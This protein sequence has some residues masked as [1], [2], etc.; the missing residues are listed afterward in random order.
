MH[1]RHVC[2]LS[3]A[4][5]RGDAT[6]RRASHVSERADRLRWCVCELY[7]RRAPLRRLRSRLCHGTAVCRWYLHGYT[8]TIR[9][10]HD[11]CASELFGGPSIL[12][13]VLCR[14]EHERDPLRRL[15][16][17]LHC[18]ATL[19]RRCMHRRDGCRSTLHGHH[20]GLLF[21]G[22]RELARQPDALWHV[23]Q[24]LPRGSDLRRWTLRVSPSHGRGPDVSCGACVLPRH[25]CR[26]CE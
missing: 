8:A 20:H 16:S 13:W 2:G 4:A 19:R 3:S 11:G 7:E 9:C 26:H 15:W 18:G 22:V 6:P 12:C 14:H 5:R 24:R 21:G 10:G 1:G 17:R 25:V 23:R